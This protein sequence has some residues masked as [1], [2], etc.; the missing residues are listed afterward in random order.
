MYWSSFLAVHIF[1][2]TKEKFQSLCVF[3]RCWYLR[4]TK[5]LRVVEILAEE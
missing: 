1:I 5:L 2:N 3:R 4:H